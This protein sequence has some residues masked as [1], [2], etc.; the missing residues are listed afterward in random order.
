MAETATHRRDCAFVRTDHWTECDCGLSDRLLGAALRAALATVGRGWEL[1]VWRYR[2]GTFGCGK[3][4]ED[5]GTCGN[6]ECRSLASLLSRTPTTE[7]RMI[8]D[9]TV[10]PDEVHLRNASGQTVGKIVG[11]APRTPTTEEQP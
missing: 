8:A 4:N 10:P 1:R 5:A 6:P 11:L 9:P 7:L 2:D 3:H